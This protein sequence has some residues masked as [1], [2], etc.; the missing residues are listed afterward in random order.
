MVRKE[1]ILVHTDLHVG[2]AR[3]SPSCRSDKNLDVSVPSDVSTSPN[4]KKNRKV[5]KKYGRKRKRKKEARREIKCN[6]A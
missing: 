5:K 1:G 4:T 6:K 3:H 2:Y